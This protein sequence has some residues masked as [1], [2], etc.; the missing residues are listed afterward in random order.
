LHL[1]LSTPIYTY[2]HQKK[3]FA[4]RHW[5][6]PDPGSQPPVLT[7][8]SVLTGQALLSFSGIAGHTYHV[9][10]APSASSSGAAWIDLGSATTNDAGNAQFTDASPIP[11]QAYYRVVWKR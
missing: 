9:E 1:Q 7:R 3:L 4:L 2:L 5:Q 10:R 6:F 11:G 8:L